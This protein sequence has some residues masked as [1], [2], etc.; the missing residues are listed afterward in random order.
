MREDCVGGEV[1]GTTATSF[2]F[3]FRGWGGYSRC[4]VILLV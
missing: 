4:I 1:G 2:L 3:W